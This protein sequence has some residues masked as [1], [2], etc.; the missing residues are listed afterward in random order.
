MSERARIV[1]KLAGL[2]LAAGLAGGGAW[3]FQHERTATERHIAEL[4]RQIEYLEDVAERLVLEERAAKILVT[5]QDRSMD[6]TLET[7][8]LFF[9]VDANGEE[10]PAKAFT[11]RGEQIYVSALVI[12]F[13]EEGV[14]EGDPLTGKSIRLWDKI[15]G[16]AEPAEGGQAIEAQGEQPDAYGGDPATRGLDPQRAAFEAELWSDFWRMAAD[17]EYARTKG[18]KVAFGQAVYS[19]FEPGKVY[20]ITMQANGGLSLYSEP[21]PALLRE[22]LKAIDPTTRA[23]S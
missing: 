2:A 19:V 3:W 12:R 9:D 11:V 1:T 17:T 23:G 4:D 21:M 20:E 22:S 18:V 16:S 15:Y 13:P 6:G 10:R 8:L 14:E 5:G 7:D